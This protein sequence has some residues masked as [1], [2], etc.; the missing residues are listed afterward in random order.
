MLKA[1]EGESPAASPRTEFPT[2][3]ITSV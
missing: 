1:G 3:A 2:T